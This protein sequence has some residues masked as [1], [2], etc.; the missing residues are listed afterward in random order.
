[1]REKWTQQFIHYK[2]LLLGDKDYREL[3]HWTWLSAIFTIAWMWLWYIVTILSSRWFG[4]DWMW[5]LAMINTIIV[6]AW[7]IAGLGIQQSVV[8]YINQRQAQWSEWKTRAIHWYILKAILPFSLI[9]S[10][11]LY[12]WKWRIAQSLFHEPRLEGVITRLSI[13]LPMIV[14]GNIWLAI[15]KWYKQLFVYH[16]INKIGKLVIQSVII[17]AIYYWSGSVFGP[18]RALYGAAT[19]WFL[20]SIPFVIQYYKKLPE[21]IDLPKKEILMTSLPMM[22]TGLAAVLITQTDIFMLSLYTDT[23]QVGIYQTA[24]RVAWL[25]AFGLTVI[26]MIAWQQI[27]KLYRSEKKQKLKKILKLATI[28]SAIFG[29]FMTL[30]II[31]FSSFIMWIFWKEFVSWETLLIIIALWQFINVVAGPVWLYMNM[32]WRQKIQ[33]YIFLSIGALNIILNILLIPNYWIEGAA[34]AS[35]ICLTINN[36]IHVYY[37]WRKDKILFFST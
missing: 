36:I 2:V 3:L 14:L 18:I 12:I 25:I 30:I 33:Q 1:M 11:L 29:L 4:A 20:L 9:I 28:W 16:S 32:T 35:A 27:A 19:W 37:I 31:F 5:L 7:A 13:V 17:I 23:A 24:L 21:K 22:V 6:F 34:T 26:N 8:R 15:I 10:F